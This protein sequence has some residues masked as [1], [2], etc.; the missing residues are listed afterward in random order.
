MESI[1][2]KRLKNDLPKRVDAVLED[3]AFKAERRATLVRIAFAI[4]FL[5][6]GLARLLSSE[7]EPLLFALAAAWVIDALLVSTLMR[8]ETRTDALVR[9]TTIVDF[10]ILHLGLIAGLWLES[11]SLA[12]VLIGYFPLL[13]I[14]SMRYRRLLVII[15]AVY[16]GVV[17]AIADLFTDAQIWPY[18]AL[19]EVTAMIGFLA[20]GKPKNLIVGVASNS[21]QEAFDIGARQKEIEMNNLFHEALFPPAQIDL[22]AIWSSSKHTA[23]TET[24][25]DYYHIFE[26]ERG[27][28]VILGD[29]DCPVGTALTEVAAL[30]QQLLKII[31]RESDPGRILTALNTWLYDKYQGKRRFSC[32]AANWEG[33]TMR[34]INA[35]HLPAFRLSAKLER[36]KIGVNSEPL[37]AERDAQYTVEEIPFQARELLVIYTDGLYGKVT[38]ERERGISEI[39]SLLEKF[40]HGEVNT[41]CHRV[42]DCAQ[43]GIEEPADDATLVVVRRQPRAAE[44]AKAHSGGK[45]Q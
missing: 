5:A 41:I 21:L 31:S 30:H 32:V 8:R 29:L 10:T 19:F 22:P 35:G 16:A 28:L 38:N 7:R 36:S 42:F 6:T 24:G 39:E 37:G 44:E 40:S 34:Y 15:C 25:G 3:Q 18:L 20:S 26:T 27:P 33:E 23:G 13:A 14:A 1:A 12:L 43:P 2:L 9:W 17:M 4:I 45:E 11:S